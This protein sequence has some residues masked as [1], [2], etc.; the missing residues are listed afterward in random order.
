MF[1]ITV[2]LS[3][4]LIIVCGVFFFRS[5]SGYTFGGDYGYATLAFD[6]LNCTLVFLD[7]ELDSNSCSKNTFPV[8]GFDWQ[9]SSNTGTAMRYGKHL[10]YSYHYYPLQ[11]KSIWDVNNHKVQILNAGKRI[12]INNELFDLSDNQFF[13]ILI[14][15]NKIIPVFTENNDFTA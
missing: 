11:S 1:A 9:H 14:S 4:I 15:E 3:I 6:K 12:K 13:L 8:Y 10:Y 2:I 5:S 7:I